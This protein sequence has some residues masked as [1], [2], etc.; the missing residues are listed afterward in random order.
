MQAVVSKAD[1]DM[2]EQIARWLALRLQVQ[3]TPVQLK[4]LN[5]VIA[6]ASAGA[7]AFCRAVSRPAADG[8]VAAG[9]LAAQ[10]YTTEP[11]PDYGDKPQQVRDLGHFGVV[12]RPFSGRSLS[13]LGH[14]G[15]DRW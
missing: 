9:V 1:L 4:T 5:L 7:P 8:T 11:H 10:E 6:L 14:L 12:C 2:A 15:A 3:S 13:F